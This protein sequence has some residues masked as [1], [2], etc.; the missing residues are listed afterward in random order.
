MANVSTLDKVYRSLLLTKFFTRGWGKPEHMKR[1]FS[2]R[3]KLG[4]RHLAVNFVSP[5]HEVVIEKEYTKSKC[6]ILDGYFR[7][8]M[9]DHLD[10]LVPKECEN[11]YFQVVLPE[12]RNQQSCQPM[13]VQFA[14]TGDHCKMEIIYL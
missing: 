12:K 10:E 6:R 5:N 8:P 9:C 3:K 4:Q 14:G 13:C 11:A 1:I 7:S 2:L